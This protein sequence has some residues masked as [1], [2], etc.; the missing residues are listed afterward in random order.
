MNDEIENFAYA[1]S[2]RV[3]TTEIVREKKWGTHRDGRCVGNLVLQLH[4]PPSFVLRF[5]RWRNVCGNTAVAR[6]SKRAD[7][8]VWR[9]FLF[10][11]LSYLVLFLCIRFSRGTNVTSTQQR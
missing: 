4:A 5:G 7:L 11:F 10:L 2:R 8:F 9:Y 3:I 6:E 1:I